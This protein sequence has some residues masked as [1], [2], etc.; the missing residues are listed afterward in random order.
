MGDNTLFQVL[1]QALFNTGLQPYKYMIW[2][3]E[4]YSFNTIELS[5]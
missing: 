4:L 5:N 3:T 2:P 1:P